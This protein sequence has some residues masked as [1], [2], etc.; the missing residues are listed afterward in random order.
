[1]TGPKTGVYCAKSHLE[2]SIGPFGPGLTLTISKWPRVTVV[3]LIP[4]KIRDES[5]LLRLCS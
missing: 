5:Q 2:K 3:S 1:M 4:S